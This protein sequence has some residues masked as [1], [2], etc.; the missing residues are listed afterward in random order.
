MREIS[1][2]VK[3]TLKDLKQLGYYTVRDPNPKKVDIVAVYQ[4]DGIETS[5][6]RVIC[7]LNSDNKNKVWSAKNKLDKFKF[8]LASKE[9]WIYTENKVHVMILQEDEL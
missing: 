7:V 2:V 1:D 6:Y 8:P 3:E 4:E 5:A 9:I